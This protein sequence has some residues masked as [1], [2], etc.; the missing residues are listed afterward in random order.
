M[1]IQ[2]FAAPLFISIAAVL[3]ASPAFSIGSCSGGN[4][5][6]RQVTC[7]V[8]GDTIW[9]KGVKMRLEAIDAPEVSHPECAREKMLGDKAA[10]RLINLMNG[11]YSIRDTHKKGKFGR[12]L[13][14]VILSDGRDAGTVLRKEGLAQPWPNSGNVWCGRK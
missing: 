7:V 8:D 6:A 13:V 14:Y 12:E 2:S 3:A 10:N 4:R 5:A 11:G 9:I 1:K